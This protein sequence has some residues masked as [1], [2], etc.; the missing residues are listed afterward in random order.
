MEKG[1]V[2]C[3]ILLSASHFNH[4]VLSAKSMAGFYCFYGSREIT[5][6]LPVVLCMSS[7]ADAAVTKSAFPLI[8]FG[9]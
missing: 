7:N 1:C 9:C 2:T 8:V 5:W 4:N 3:I 6:E